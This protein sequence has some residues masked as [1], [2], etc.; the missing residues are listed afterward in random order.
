[1]ATKAFQTRG[2]I[3]DIET[4]VYVKRKLEW[5]D[6]KI[7]IKEDRLFYEI[8][9]AQHV[10]ILG[11]RQTGKTS[12]LF[13]LEDYLK[14]EGGYVSINVDLSPGEKLEDEERWYQYVANQ[15]LPEEVSKK[16]SISEEEKKEWVGSV[17]D[18]PTFIYFLDQIG[19]KTDDK[20]VLMLDEFGAVPESLCDS[21]FTAIRSIINRRETKW[22]FVL[23]GA[24]NPDELISRKRKTSPFNVTERFYMQDF[25]KNGTREVVENLKGFH[26]IQSEEEQ[27]RIV[28]YIHEQTGGH[29]YLVQVVCTRLEN[30]DTISI[31]SVNSA[32]NG[33]P[34][35]QRVYDTLEYDNKAKQ[36]LKQI[37]EGKKKVPKRN[38]MVTKLELLG[39]IKK[40]GGG[41]FVI[42]N[43]IYEEEL[44]DY[45]KQ[46]EPK[47]EI[48]EDISKIG[49]VL[50]GILALISIFIG[51]SLSLWFAIAG[52]I[53]VSIL[54]GFIFWKRDRISKN[55]FIF[56]LLCIFSMAILFL[57]IIFYGI[58]IYLKVSDISIENPIRLNFTYPSILS[59]DE[60]GKIRTDIINPKQAK[61]VTL[62]LHSN[63][64]LRFVVDGGKLEKKI[65]FTDLTSGSCRESKI[66][67]SKARG[68]YCEFGLELELNDGRKSQPESG[69][70]RI[71]SVPLKII[72]WVLFIITAIVTLG[73]LYSLVKNIF[74]NQIIIILK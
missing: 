46:G 53:M 2:P 37:L 58:W 19:T 11:A 51:R 44:K 20:I 21:F 14:E 28:E 24:T 26:E 13:Q 48:V 45:F 32:T 33:L 49:I 54:G 42:H 1:M 6:P 62:I 18:E 5:E 40:S 57:L 41:N 35:P 64:D 61:S 70:I 22:T 43:P 47:R 55:M 10:T 27:N 66:K 16:L 3:T 52:F 67:I 17:K 8:S 25:D 69:R 56:V 36:L 68:D 39:V 9:R 73:G 59:I 34:L 29:P 65:T 4:T 50:A 12:L 7:I 72:K 15:I 30:S 60:E 23:A 74:G 38:K 63:D 31:E 71:W